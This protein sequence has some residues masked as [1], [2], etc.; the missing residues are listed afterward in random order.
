MNLQ[1]SRLLPEKPPWG[2]NAYLGLAAYPGKVGHAAAGYT[3]GR[4]TACAYTNR[5]NAKPGNA[6]GRGIEN[7]AAFRLT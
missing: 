1:R 2:G 3:A 4:Y 7:A 6:K 5:G